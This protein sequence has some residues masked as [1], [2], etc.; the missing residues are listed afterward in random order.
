MC[1]TS[2]MFDREKFFRYFSNSFF[3]HRCTLVPVVRSFV[4]S[5]M[6]TQNNVTREKVSDVL[7]I[8]PAIVSSKRYGVMAR[9][10]VG[11]LLH[12]LRNDGGNHFITF[13]CYRRSSW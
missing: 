4:E 5:S 10:V 1:V 3:A 6:S 13:D 11:L 9:V 12:T 7:P 2:S 8:T